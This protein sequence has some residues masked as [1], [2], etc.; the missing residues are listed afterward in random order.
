MALADI[1][2]KVVVVDVMMEKA[3]GEVVR[4]DYPNLAAKASL[5][6]MALGTG[7]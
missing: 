1:A 4:A 3:Y 7:S 2:G 5:E 6:A